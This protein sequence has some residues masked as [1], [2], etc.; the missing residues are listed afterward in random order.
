MNVFKISYLNSNQILATLLE[1]SQHF[2]QQC[3]CFL[4]IVGFLNEY[5]SCKNNKIPTQGSITKI[6]LTDLNALKM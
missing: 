1:Y 4:L 5:F 6:Y 2:L 3:L